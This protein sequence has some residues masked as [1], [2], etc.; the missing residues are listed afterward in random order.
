M[1]PHD[2]QVVGAVLD[3][4][5]NGAT[6]W[7]PNARA[8]ALQL[9]RC[10]E[11]DAAEYGDLDLTHAS[12]TLRRACAKRAATQGM[13]ADAGV[14]PQAVVEIVPLRKQM[15][16]KDVMNRLLDQLPQVK[17]ASSYYLEHCLVD[18][19]RT[20]VID[21][22]RD[23]G[24]LIWGYDPRQRAQVYRRD[25]ESERKE[26]ERRV[27][28]DLSHVRRQIE[29]T[30]YT[31]EVA[32]AR[33]PW[34]CEARLPYPDELRKF[35]AYNAKPIQELREYPSRLDFVRTYAKG[36]GVTHV[37]D[38]IDVEERLRVHERQIERVI[39]LLNATKQ[40][41]VP[42]HAFKV[43]DLVWLPEA[44]IM[45]S[46]AAPRLAVVENAGLI[47][48]RWR[49]ISTG[50]VGFYAPEELTLVTSVGFT[51]KS[52]YALLRHPKFALWN[53]PVSVTRVGDDI[54]WQS[55]GPDGEMRRFVI[56]IDAKV[57]TSIVK[58]K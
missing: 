25:L 15:Y 19:I 34:Q 26:R 56:G 23:G 50:D 22:V 5:G 55:Q 16:V 9:Y 1:N 46:Y 49:G 28:D 17:A 18:L 27:Y 40:D 52:F 7:T 35:M 36:Q 48:G 37:G 44:R 47:D 39:A 42:P 2:P 30:L 20:Y 6:R 43:G 10:D 57:K 24:E 11:A 21:S 51:A 53:Q 13:L 54:V 41:E 31:C 58:T 8:L 4:I 32:W 38:D 14:T 33:T 12:S 45:G 3:E 29:Q